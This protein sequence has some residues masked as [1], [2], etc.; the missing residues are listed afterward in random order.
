MGIHIH[1]WWGP[2][3]LDPAY[4]DRLD[5]LTQFVQER[6]D[7]MSQAVDT[8][9]AQVRDLEDA[10]TSLETMV[11]GLGAQI[12]ANAGDEEAERAL[13]EEVTAK[14]AEIRAAITANTPSTPTPPVTPP[15]E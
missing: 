8:L 2:A 7:H 13:G 10:A 9:I 3:P 14:T 6:M 12:I 1:V 5:T 11:A 4:L 15:T